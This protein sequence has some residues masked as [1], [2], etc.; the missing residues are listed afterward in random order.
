VE[1]G[2]CQADEQSLDYANNFTIVFQDST[3]IKQLFFVDLNFFFILPSIN[4]T[5]F[6]CLLFPN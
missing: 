1:E 2:F 4:P 3:S 6:D 5:T